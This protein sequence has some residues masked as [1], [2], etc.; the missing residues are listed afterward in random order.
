[1][2]PVLAE[3]LITLILTF[4]QA[5]ADVPDMD[6]VGDYRVTAYAYYEGGGENYGTASGAAPVPYYTVATTNEFEFGT[7]L[8]IEDIGIVEVQDRG[9]FPEGIIDLHIGWDSMD[10]FDDRIRKVYVV[11]R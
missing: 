5:P 8:Y 6:Y 1:V 4:S 9:S 11:R 3:I 2:I 10:S 7:L